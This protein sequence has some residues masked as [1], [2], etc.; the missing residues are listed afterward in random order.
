MTKPPRYDAEGE[1]INEGSSRIVNLQYNGEPV[2]AEQ[3]FLVA[4]NNY[5][6]SGGGNFPNLDGT[7]IVIDSPDENRQVIINYLTEEE[8]GEP[9][10]R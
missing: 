2:T 9:L 7:T 8:H 1:L 10:R 4:T 5:R 6:A 3:E